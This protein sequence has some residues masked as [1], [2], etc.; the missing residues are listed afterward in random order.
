MLASSRPTHWPNAIHSEHMLIT[1]EQAREILAS[2]NGK[3]RA[4]RPNTVAK[5]ANDIKEGRWQCTHQGI[6][7]DENNILIDGQHRLHAIVQ[8]NKACEM[9]VTYNVSRKT[10]SVLDCGVSRT[11]SDNL[12]YSN[13]PRAKLVAPAIKHI[14][15]CHRFP[16]RT[17]SNL[18]FPTHSEI[19]NF[20][21]KN[22][23]AIDQISALVAETSRQF[24]KINPTGLAVTCY[25]AFE[26]GHSMTTIAAFCHGLGMGSGLSE[27]NPLLTYR[28]FII[29]LKKAA[30]VDRNLQ[31]YSTACLIK[32]FNYWFENK[33]LRQFKAPKFP[34]M[35]SIVQPS[36]PN[37]A[38]LSQH[39]KAQVLAQANYTCQKC[40]AKQSE[41]A[42]LQVDHIIPRSKGGTNNLNNLQCLCSVCNNQKSDN[43]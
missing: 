26:A 41:G 15:L 35:P 30:P 23:D 13:V 14:L 42:A 31:Q 22:S 12:A 40:G 37:F 28:Q 39:V 19:F 9:L 3:N 34:P 27:F 2:R 25:L 16:K 17:W 29:N 20:Y 18:P 7:F 33:E 6:A 1:P 21:E 10:F 36:L 5:I 32:A 38:S 43:L 8:A 4:V 24:K 11:A